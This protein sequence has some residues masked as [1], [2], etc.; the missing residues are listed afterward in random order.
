MSGQANIPAAATNLASVAIGQV[1]VVVAKN[2]GTVLNW[3]HNGYG[4]LATPAGLSNVMAL[5]AGYCNTLALCSN[6]TVV[7]W[8]DDTY[9]ISTP[10]PGLTNVAA[11]AAGP[12]RSLALQA[13]GTLVAWG[14]DNGLPSGLSHLVAIAR[15]NL[16]VQ[17]D[18]AV[19]Q[20]GFNSGDVTNTVVGPPAS[21]AYATAIAAG[22]AHYIGLNVDG[23]VIGW[24]YNYVGQLNIPPGLSNVVAIAAGNV[25]TLAL[26]ADGSVVAWGDNSAGQCDVPAGLTN[27]IAVAAGGYTSAALVGDGPPSVTLQPFSQSALAG[28]SV[29]LHA[30]AAGIPPLTFQWQKGETDLPGATQASLILTDVSRADSGSYRSVVTGAV[31][32]TMSTPA[33]LLVR[34]PQ[35]L[36]AGQVLSDGSFTATSS[37]AGENSISAADLPRFEVQSSTDLVNWISLSD[38]LS[39]TNGVLLLRDPTAAGRAN[40]FYRIFEY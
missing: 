23:T 20:W 21:L 19:I 11:I 24:G 2:D 40:C 38:A 10:P 16:A 4:Q 31:G 1:H 8:G 13:D 37:D 32:E 6:G 14:F 33:T 12:N 30:R 3:G 17:T 15:Q 28:S 5:A 34:S 7:A 35:R 36:C 27:V 26:V 18:G 22:Q 25:H 9:G 39:L 29:Q